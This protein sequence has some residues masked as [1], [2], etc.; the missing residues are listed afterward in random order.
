VGH[1]GPGESNIID[2]LTDEVANQ[3]VDEIAERAV[4]GQ[5]CGPVGVF[6]DIH[7]ILDEKRKQKLLNDKS[8]QAEKE[9]NRLKASLL[10]HE[11]ANEIV[12]LSGG[13]GNTNEIA[14]NFL[15]QYWEWE[16]A[17][18]NYNTYINL[19]RNYGKKPEGPSFYPARSPRN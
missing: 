5:L 16:K 7:N 8:P 1:E 6:V 3:L 18:N 12:R 10:A 2:L 15:L 19:D 14:A 9:R 13:R 17:F 4:G 11:F